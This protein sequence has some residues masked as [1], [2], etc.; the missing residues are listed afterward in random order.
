MLVACRL[1]GLSAPVMYYA[2]SAWARNSD[3]SCHAIAR[4]SHALMP[5]FGRPQGAFC[6][7]AGL[8]VRGVLQMSRSGLNQ[9]DK[10][11]FHT[12]TM[13]QLRNAAGRLCRAVL[14][15][16]STID[17]IDAA[18]LVKFRQIQSRRNNLLKGRTCSPRVS[19][20]C[21]RSP[22]APV[23]R[24]RHLLAFR[25]LDRCQFGQQQR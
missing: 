15:E 3:P 24:H 19:G 9:S 7:G 11:D 16:V 17:F 20:R 12:C 4:A 21:S 18:Q 22:V 10:L 23:W 1:A 2:G 25:S 5:G 14:R 8:G 13:I 6:R